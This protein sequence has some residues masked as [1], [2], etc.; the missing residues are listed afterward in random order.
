MVKTLSALKYTISNLFSEKSDFTLTSL[1]EQL[2]D[3]KYEIDANT[4]EDLLLPQFEKQYN[5]TF[6]SCGDEVFNHWL[7]S[8]KSKI[9]LLHYKVI[10]QQQ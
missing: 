10:L 9:K 3:Y 4:Y 7:R 5:K 6:T 2:Y 8:I 1:H